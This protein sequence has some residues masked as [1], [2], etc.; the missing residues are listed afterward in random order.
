MRL[1]PIHYSLTINLVVMAIAGGLAYAFAQPLVFVL[2][3]LLSNHALERF[4]NDQPGPGPGDEDD[5]DPD[6]SDS[7]AGFTAQISKS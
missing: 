5:E 2:A 7:R 6:Y 3:V 1:H 4:R